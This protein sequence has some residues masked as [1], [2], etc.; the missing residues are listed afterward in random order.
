ML[1]RQLQAVYNG[2][3]YPKRQRKGIPIWKRISEK[4]YAQLAM[5]NSLVRHGQ[6]IFDM[7]M[8]PFLSNRSAVIL[9]GFLW[10]DV[11]CF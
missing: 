8:T 3:R 9:E 4:L 1:D 5:K 7:Q 6:D 11:P 2:T 10:E